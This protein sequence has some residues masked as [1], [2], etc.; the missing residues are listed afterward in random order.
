MDIDKTVFA[1][2]FLLKKL[3]NSK[4]CIKILNHICSTGRI[5]RNPIDKSSQKNNNVIT[6]IKQLIKG[7]T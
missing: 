7:N 5:L 1:G 2:P 6:L 4:M 3:S